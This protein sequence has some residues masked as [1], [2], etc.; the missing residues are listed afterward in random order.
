MQKASQ[1]QIWHDA[2]HAIGLKNKT[3]EGKPNQTRFVTD[4]A[5]ASRMEGYSEAL[6]VLAAL[7]GI[8]A[9]AY[10]DR[11]VVAISL[12][13]LYV[14]PLSLSALTR[15]R[16][17]TYSLVGVCVALHDWL[18]PYEHTG[19]QVLHRSVLTLIG[20]TVVALFVG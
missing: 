6:L 5:R 15:Y 18:G 1:A 9:V 12:G 16:R 20:F 14:L 11:L 4:H 2:M 3:T 19:W 10:A 17:T 7:A 13:Y 8:S